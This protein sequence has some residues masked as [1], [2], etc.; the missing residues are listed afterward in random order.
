MRFLN[1]DF[2][3]TRITFLTNLLCTYPPNAFRDSHYNPAIH[4]LLF[5]ISKVISSQLHPPIRLLFH[6]TANFIFWHHA[7]WKHVFSWAIS[8]ANVKESTIQEDRNFRIAK[9]KKKLR[10]PFCVGKNNLRIRNDFR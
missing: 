8:C 7:E 3:L 10:G 2:S 1:S 4:N 9:N 6:L 5:S